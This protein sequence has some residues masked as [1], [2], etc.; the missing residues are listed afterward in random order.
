MA[1]YKYQIFVPGGNKTALVLGLDG[2]KDDISLRKEIQDKILAERKNDADGEVEQ[3]GFI[4]AD[5]S[6]P[7]I[8]MAGGEFCGNATRSATAYYLGGC[9]GE[10]RIE[11]LVYGVPKPLQAGITSPKDVWAQM[12]IYEDI[13]SAVTTV[14]NRFF[15]VCMDGISHLIVPQSQ[16][17]LYFNDVFEN[18]LCNPTAV[19]Y[20]ILSKIADENSLDIGNACGIIFLENV[21]NTLKMHPFVYIKNSGTTYYETGCG[22]GAM[23]VGLVKC[24]LLV[25]SVRLPL[26]QPSGK[27]ITTEV[28]H[29]DNGSV[30]G[31]ISGEVSRGD[32][33]EVEV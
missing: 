21:L 6:A 14:K 12:P 33:F 4:D 15:W 7:C 8:I 30:R 10:I 26:L 2:L 11:A 1:H 27:F 25:E 18:R 20:G 13:S 5:K 23:C 28:E 17:P 29:C 31:K 9:E 32:V 3:V 24:F 22:S 16:F 19:A